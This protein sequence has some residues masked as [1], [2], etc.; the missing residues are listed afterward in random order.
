L[1]RLASCDRFSGSANWRMS[2][3]GCL[4]QVAATKHVAN[5]PCARILNNALWL[6]DR[7]SPISL[8]RM[9]QFSSFSHQR[10]RREFHAQLEKDTRKLIEA[11]E[12]N[13]TNDR[14]MGSQ[15]LS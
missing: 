2:H 9:V 15:Q 8:K 11:F 3:N 4:R 5:G 12:R 14:L 13:I 1:E 7:T 10:R 6:S